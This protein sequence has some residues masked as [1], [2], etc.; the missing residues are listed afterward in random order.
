MTM[1]AIW[2]ASYLEETHWERR[3]GR[4]LPFRHAE[5]LQTGE[6]H[7]NCFCEADSQL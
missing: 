3:S 1:P 6:Q 2:L 7:R 4:P 5:L